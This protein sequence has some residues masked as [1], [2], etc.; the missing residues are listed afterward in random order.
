MDSNSRNE[1][2]PVE[3]AED[4]LA[5]LE[6]KI[7]RYS[8]KI[9][10][11]SKD[12]ANLVSIREKLTDTANALRRLLGKPTKTNITDEFAISEETIKKACSPIYHTWA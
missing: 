5:T 2:F 12:L 1:D 7:T 8:N 10:T 3:T 9:E 11:T 4:Y 6:E